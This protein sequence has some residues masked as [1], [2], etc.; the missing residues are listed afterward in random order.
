MKNCGNSISFY[1]R[2]ETCSLQLI[3]SIFNRFVTDRQEP[4]FEVI[5]E[6]LEDKATK[7]SLLSGQGPVLERVKNELI[8]F[9]TEEAREGRTVEEYARSRNN[10]LQDLLKTLFAGLKAALNWQT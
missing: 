10:S 7:F 8:E 2:F 5:E 1:V 3:F 4:I 9:W 6:L